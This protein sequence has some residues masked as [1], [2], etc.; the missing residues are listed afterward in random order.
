MLSISP[1]N[2]QPPNS[3]WH[4]KYASVP[5]WYCF[6]HLSLTAVI[7]CDFSLLLYSNTPTNK[8]PLTYTCFN[9]SHIREECVI[10]AALTLLVPCHLSKS[11][12][13][14]THFNPELRNLKGWVLEHFHLS[15]SLLFYYCYTCLHK[16]HTDKVGQSILIFPTLMI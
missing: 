6:S 10:V 13:P 1:R 8:C 14:L 15:V 7:D 4:L 2:L 9:M 3:R 16:R 5:V 11:H 12:P